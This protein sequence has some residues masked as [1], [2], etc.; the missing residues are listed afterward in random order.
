VKSLQTKRRRM[1][2]EGVATQFYIVLS[3]FITCVYCSWSFIHLM[4][5]CLWH[6]CFCR[7]TLV[8]MVTKVKLVSEMI[9]MWNANKVDGWK[10]DDR[11][12]VMAI[13][14]MT[15]QN[16]RSKGSVISEKMIKQDHLYGNCILYINVYVT[17]LNTVM[18]IGML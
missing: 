15:Q 7:N 14:H 3:G 2:V 4:K 18:F 12:K 13:V 5:C 6:R 17:L 8:A 1:P 11:T 10:T 9:K 16:I